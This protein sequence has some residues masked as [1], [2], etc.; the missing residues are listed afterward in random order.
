MSEQ[1]QRLDALTGLGAGDVEQHKT[2]DLQKQEKRDKHINVFAT[3]ANR[4]AAH[5][6]EL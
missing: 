4:M 1:G 2:F 3:E 6:R 5:R